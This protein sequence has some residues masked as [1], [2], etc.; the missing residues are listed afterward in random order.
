ML[1]KF[2]RSDVFTNQLKTYPHVSFH[3]YDRHVYYN[4]IPSQSGQ[5]S[6]TGTIDIY[7]FHFPVY[8]FITKGGSKTAFKS[9]SID[10]FNQDFKYGDI[11]RGFYPLSASISSVY[12]GANQ[13]R[14]KIDALRNVLTDY[15]IL[16]RH[17]ELSSSNGDKTIQE[18]RFI[19][20]PSIVIGSSIRKGSVSLKFF[21]TGT[22]AGELRDDKQKGVLRQAFPYGNN[23]GSIAGVVL[24]RHAGIILTGAWAINT[25]HT[26]TYVGSSTNPRWVDFATTGSVV[27][28]SNVPSSSFMLE[29]QGTQYIP[30]LTMFAHL[31]KGE[32]NYS[33]NPTF[34]S[35]NQS[36]SLTPLTSSKEYKEYVDLEIKNIN[37]SSFINTTASFQNIVYV[38]S[39]KIFDKNK[40]LIAIAKL[41]NPIKKK[42]VNEYTIKMKLDLG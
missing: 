42:E 36:G 19:D 22:L 39:V 32:L 26:E 38:S 17:Y 33:N 23:S 14:P 11:I 1:Y 4:N 12:L 20:I 30:T 10:Q 5:S 13:T 2:D 35:Y 9:V 8:P 28:G 16:S 25:S 18:L 7:G 41:A 29:F 37:K 40:N 6:N 27:I 21:I 15:S 3:I 24:Y 34:I 31:P